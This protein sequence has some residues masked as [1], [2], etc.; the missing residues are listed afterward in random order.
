MSISTLMTSISPWS[1][2]GGL[3]AQLQMDPLSAALQSRGMVLA[4]LIV[5]VL[6][7]AATWFVI[8]ARVWALL[9]LRQQIELFRA[10]FNKQEDL[11]TA[12]EA[13]RGHVALP[14]FKLLIAVL[15][16]IA[17]YGPDDAIDLG[18]VERTLRRAAEP[19]VDDL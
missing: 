10:G 14:H 12:A 5:L 17:R 1:S 2:F 4:V 16:E 9:Q 3:L 7:S 6:M 13:L 15:K 19:L 18:S 11:A 8:G